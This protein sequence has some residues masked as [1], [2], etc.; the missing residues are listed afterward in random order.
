[1]TESDPPQNRKSSWLVCI[2]IAVSL[3]INGSC[4]NYPEEMVSPDI[5][6]EA[7]INA[8]II[9]STADMTKLEARDSIL[10]SL[11]ISSND[12][13]TFVNFHW[14]DVDFMAEIWDEIEAGIDQGL[15]EHTLVP[16]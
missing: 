16:Q 8:Y 2:L 6:R 9:L 5:N 1:M 12:L 10:H 15:N 14:S 13:E 11:H 7:F 4:T 3:F